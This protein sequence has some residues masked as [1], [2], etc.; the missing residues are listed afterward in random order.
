MSKGLEVPWQ[1]VL[2]S[3]ILFVFICD[4]LM[5]DNVDVRLINYLCLTFVF[6]FHHYN[7]SDLQCVFLGVV[8]F[9][10]GT[11]CTFLC[12]FGHLL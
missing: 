7:V 1:M 9:C 3:L 11:L 12:S 2:S 8:P 5:Y 4:P 6:S 10:C